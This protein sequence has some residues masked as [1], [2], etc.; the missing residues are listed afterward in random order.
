MSD[1]EMEIKNK[2]AQIDEN[3]MDVTGG[4]FGASEEQYS[5]MMGKFQKARESILSFGIGQNEEPRNVSVLN[6]YANKKS[7]PPIK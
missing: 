7:R 4:I 2:A 1:K 6:N 3:L 5:S